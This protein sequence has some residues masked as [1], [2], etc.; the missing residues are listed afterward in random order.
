M[1]FEI[2]LLTGHISPRPRRQTESL[3]KTV[4]DGIGEATPEKAGLLSPTDKQKLDNLG[5]ASTEKAGLLSPEDKQK[6][7]NLGE[8]QSAMQSVTWAELVALRSD[9]KLTPGAYYR[10]TDYVTTTTQVDTRSAGHAFDI[11]VRADS[12]NIL[13][14]NAFAVRHEGDTYFA[15]SNLAAWQLKYCL[16]ND[17]SRFAWADVED[18]KGVIFFMRDEFNNECPYDFKNIQ[19]KR[20]KIEEGDYAGEYLAWGG[21]TYVWAYTFSQLAWDEE[22]EEATYNTILDA[23]IEN[24]SYA[25][26]SDGG[27]YAHPIAYCEDN[28]IGKTIA[29]VTLDDE[30]LYPAALYLSY[31]VF[32]SIPQNYE[33]LGNIE[34]KH[35]AKNILNDNCKDNLFVA[36]SGNTLGYACKGNT[37]CFEAHSNVLGVNCSDNWFGVECSYN[38]FGNYC[39]GNMFGNYC[40]RNMFGN[41]C[42]YNHCENNI[43]QVKVS[44]DYFCNNTIHSNVRYVEVSCDDTE[45]GEVRNVLIY[46]GI[47]GVYNDPVNIEIPARNG[48]LLEVKSAAATTLEI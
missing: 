39:G 35:C 18:G 20:Y 32:F 48:A 14:E 15:K 11:I 19:Y 6:L 38:T 33:D 8:I 10:I 36:C 17:L 13:N 34:V 25:I 27:G 37:F 40:W 44:L 21:D 4:V 42:N 12:E 30:E 46:S 26:D 29:A 5:E 28:K 31:N 41:N 16:D 23:T 7:D 47:I 22:N 2:N 24:R 43:Y 9:R 1:G 45:D 3:A